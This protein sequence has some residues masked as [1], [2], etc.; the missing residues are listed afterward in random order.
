MGGSKLLGSACFAALFSLLGSGSSFS[1]E[2]TRA[3]GG[4]DGGLSDG[5]RG[6]SGVL[7][8]SCFR[9]M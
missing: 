4:K 7:L 6:R 8:S 5:V 9:D 2:E 1:G 3:I